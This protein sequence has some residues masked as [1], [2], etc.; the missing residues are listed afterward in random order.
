MK[1]EENPAISNSDLGLLFYSPDLF[2]NKKE[3]VYINKETTSLKIGSAV[4]LL[5]FFPEVF[6][7]TYIESP[8]QIEGL[9]ANFITELAIVKGFDVDKKEF[10]EIETSVAYEKSGYKMAIANVKK[11]FINSQDYIDYYKFL[12]YYKKEGTIA[13]DKSEMEIVRNCAESLYQT[14]NTFSPSKYFKLGEE[15]FSFFEDE[16][17]WKYK[18]MD[19]KSKLD[20]YT[21]DHKNKIIILID[22]KTTSKDVY[23]FRE[24]YEY[25]EYWRQ[26]AFYSNALKFHYPDYQIKQL[27]A[28][29]QTT[30]VNQS[31]LYQVCDE[32]IQRGNDRIEDGYQRWLFHTSTNQ[33]KYKKEVYDSNGILQL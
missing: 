2:K 26:I 20:S 12:A 11:N 32:D 10:S 4:H 15:L 14:I 31:L 5:L 13:L 24:S 16:V 21:I 22:V 1:Y 3:G 8:D 18:T 28:V 19:C 6:N 9:M 27:F 29:V 30:G 23:M 7:T 25:Y 33:W 17:I